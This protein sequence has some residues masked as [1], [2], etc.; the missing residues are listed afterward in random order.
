MT[1]KREKAEP[2]SSNK[3][4]YRSFLGPIGLAGLSAL[5]MLAIFPPIQW[6][7]LAFIALVPWLYVV[8]QSTSKSQWIISYLAGLIFYSLSSHWIIPITIPGYISMILYLAL[9]WPVAG[10]LIQRLTRRWSVPLFV[11]APL[12]WVSM[13]FLRTLGPMRFP[14]FFLGHSQVHQLSLIQVADL[15]GVFGV[16]L[17]VGF[18]NGAIAQMILAFKKKAFRQA[19]PAVAVTSILL[20]MTTVY[21]YWRLGQNTLRPGPTLSVIQEDYP[22][23]V[24]KESPDID[25]VLQGFMAVSIQAGKSH[26]DMLIWPE[27]CIGVPINP[28]YLSASLE[29]VQWESHNEQ[30]YAKSVVEYL[31]E[32]AQ[33]ANSYL[34]VGALSHHVNPKGHYP[35]VDKFNSALIFDRNGKYIDRYDKIRLVLFGEAVPF[36]YS[37]PR[38]YW[39]LNENMTP[40]GKNG[41]EYTLTAGKEFKRFTLP[42]NRGNFR[43]AIAICYE[44]TMSDLIAKF[45]QPINGQ[46]QIDFLVNIS[47]DGWFNHSC[48][49]LQ[50]FEVSVFR[51][52]ENRVA[53]A[54]SVNTGISGFIDPDGR[55]AGM[56]TDGSRICGP[57]IRGYLTQQVKIDSRTTLYSSIGDW[58]IIGLTSL[59]VLFGLVLP[60]FYKERVQ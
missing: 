19:I 31:G 5:L 46:K 20:I 23:F 25:E 40:Y 32:H 56:V 24:D 43:Y 44:D 36:R 8:N 47:N 38:L 52:V 45:V 35:Q 29:G 18:V 2:I 41:F 7:F 42:T 26:P 49:L 53:V 21:G 12:V 58:P 14:W 27:T 60:V 28:E 48:E 54:R 59:V 50:H 57:G 13:E 34:I 15:F 37:I 1:K 22:M 3:R 10:F 39:F 17:V 11:A 51:A 30:K 16:S 6:S 9:Y 33:I 4:S 55:I